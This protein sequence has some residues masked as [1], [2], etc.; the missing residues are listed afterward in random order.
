[1]HH[2]G[3]KIGEGIRLELVAADFNC[4]IQELKY[5]NRTNIAQAAGNFN[6]T[7]QELKL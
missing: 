7:I 6:C 1:M 5:S 4:T 3:I 2:T